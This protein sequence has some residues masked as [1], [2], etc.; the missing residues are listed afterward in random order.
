MTICFCAFRHFSSLA[1][2]HATEADV[3]VADDEEA[4]AQKVELRE[5]THGIEVYSIPFIQKFLLYV[6][7]FA[8]PNLS[9][10]VFAWWRKKKR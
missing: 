7:T 3:V 2:A 4:V 9:E 10:E 6:K 8:E 5:A 1:I